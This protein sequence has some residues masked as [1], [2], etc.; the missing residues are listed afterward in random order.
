M[1]DDSEY[2]ARREAKRKYAPGDPQWAYGV[3]WKR[4]ASRED[5]AAQWRFVLALYADPSD[6]NREQ[7]K[8]RTEAF[9]ATF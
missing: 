8:A 2:A 6:V 5:K 4:G 9:L 3:K 1:H 7:R